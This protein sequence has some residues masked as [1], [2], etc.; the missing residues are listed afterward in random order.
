MDVVII[1]GGT[2][3][4]TTAFYLRKLNKDVNITIIEKSMF[5]QFSPC[6]LPYH[7]NDE[8][9]D[10]FLFKQNDYESNKINLLL[11]TEVS[12]IDKIK[13]KVFT[14]NSEFNYDKLV[15][16]V[17][18]TSFIPNGFNGMTLKDPNDIDQIKKRCT[19]NKKVAIIGG[20]YIG[21]E[22]TNVLNK[23]G[24]NVF[25]YEIQ[26]SI[27]PMLDKDIS[28]IVLEYLE[29]NGITVNLGSVIKQ[30]GKK[31]VDGKSENEFDEIIISAGFLPNIELAKLLKLKINNG[32]IVKN[33]L[34]VEKDIYACGD[35]IEIK[36]SI[37]GNSSSMFFATH[38]VKQAEIIAENILGSK[39]KFDGVLNANI[40]D[41]GMY[42][43]SVGISSKIAESSGI[44]IITGKSK[45]TTK[46]D[47][48]KC[49]KD[50]VVKIIANE[51]GRIIGSQIVGFE[52]VAGRIDLMSLAIK[53]KNTIHDLAELETCYNPA[54][55]PM[56]SPIT[57]AAK[58]C[59]KRMR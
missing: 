36:D 6:S 7:I 28:K 48:H 55:S 1:G 12:S 59:L 40:S 57:S 38:A 20:G 19:K 4:T 24:C 52:D 27:L 11:N 34:S 54:S 43:G 46:S 29:T 15:L 10:L 56:Y 17:G 33:D 22:L 50:L 53:N 32:I 39:M 13:K 47:H 23:K 30:D 26:D 16:S 18:S 31:I 51:K 9:S 8:I 14:A 49:A 58:M 41:V 3:G 45:G 42:V 44:K 35:C 5:T 21:V 25:L 2:A 37:T